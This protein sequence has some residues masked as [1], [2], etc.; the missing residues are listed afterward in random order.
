MSPSTAPPSGP[1]PGAIG[2]GMVRFVSRCESFHCTRSSLG[3]R[4]TRSFT[5][6]P[7]ST[8]APRMVTRTSVTMPV[9]SAPKFTCPARAVVG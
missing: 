9:R 4:F 1:A 7:A 5:I 6:R 3:C 2:V 8:T